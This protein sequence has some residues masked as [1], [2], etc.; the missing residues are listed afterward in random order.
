M[1]VKAGIETYCIIDSG[2]HINKVQATDGVVRHLYENSNVKQGDYEQ[3]TVIGD[4][5]KIYL[6][7]PAHDKGRVFYLDCSELSAVVAMLKVLDM[8]NTKGENIC[9]YYR[10]FKEYDI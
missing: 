5:Y 9:N 3:I 7:S 6:K 4:R 8:Q 1:K 10:I 2:G